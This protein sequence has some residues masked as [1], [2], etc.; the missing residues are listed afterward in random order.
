MQFACKCVKEEG[1]L[2]VCAEWKIL[3]CKA[4][5]MGRFVVFEEAPVAKGNSSA[6]QWQ[7]GLVQPSRGGGRDR[8]VV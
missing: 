3:S 8:R 6:R 5:T 7:E 2:D 4:V 1:M